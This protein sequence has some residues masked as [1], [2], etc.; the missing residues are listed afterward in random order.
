MTFRGK[1]SAGVLALVLVLSSQTAMAAAPDP[2]D[3]QVAAAKSVMVSN[4]VAALDGTRRLLD[5]ARAETEP[6]K[7]AIKTSTAQ[8]LQAEALFRANRS[9]EA[10]PVIS[11]AMAGISGL[12]KSKLQGDL[13]RTRGNAYIRLGKIQLALPDMHSAYDIYRAVGETRSQSMTLMDIGTIYQNAGD[14]NRVLTYYQQAQEIY[15]SDQILAFA[16]HNNKSN[17]YMNIGKYAEALNELRVAQGIAQSIKNRAWESAA[18]SNI[19]LV[20]IK[21]ENENAARKSINDGVMFAKNHHIYDD[22]VAF[23]AMSAELDFKNRNY[24]SAL[25]NIQYT[26]R[27]LN[28]ENTP[29]SFLEFHKYA[30][31]IYAATGNDHLALQHLKAYKRID[32]ETR[33]L[34]ADTNAALMAAKFDFANQD[35]KIANLKAGQLQ[36]D[37]KLARFR[38]MITMVLLAALAIIVGLLVVGLLSLKRSRDQVRAANINLNAVNTSLE[39]ALKAKTEFLATTSHEVRTPLNGILG[40]TQVILAD[41]RVEAGMR[42]KISIVHSAAE[43][44]R[45]LVDDILDVAKIEN[46][47]LTVSREEID[48]TRI[49]DETARMWR[50]KAA[51]KSLGFKLE[52]SEA[53]KRIV[54][55][56]ARLRQ[57]LFNLLSNAIKF[58]DVGE[59]GLT[60]KVVEKDGV[61]LLALSVSDTGIGIPADQFDDVFV[62]FKQLDG[63]TTRQHGGTGL[64]LTICRNLATAMDGD[65]TIESE[66]GKGSVFI[67]TLP[68]TRVED[69]VEVVTEDNGVQ[70]GPKT[71][72]DCTVLLVE[73]N[74]L[75]QSMMKAALGANVRALE[76][77]GSGALALSA[78][79]QKHFD[80][81]LAE[82][83]AAQMPD[84][85]R[86][87]SIRTLVAAAGHTPLSVLWSQPTEQD[88]TTLTALG[89]ALVLAKPI[90]PQGI[91]E[92]LKE[93]CEA[94]PDGGESQPELKPLLTA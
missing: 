12:P 25:N 71:L 62:S 84:K 1:I 91:V 19:A 38:T 65:I 86:M 74:P 82:G 41:Q 79:E 31:E 43:T 60:A 10:L 88:I 44:M 67:V 29:P 26:F 40:M 3:E 14:Y 73:A 22:M 90:S 2:F 47:N 64:G 58:T 75:A 66:V 7:R 35:L 85:E 94:L 8:W 16:I 50:E 28:I 63:G 15:S 70:D 17:A 33:A 37:I 77:V 39:K 57:V 51:T 36:R 21:L 93:S 54:E 45:A 18:I 42:D 87:E 56:G 89:V 27:D 78:L 23:Y 52:I 80:H 34:A 20:Y 81:V 46:G 61:E 72:A 5:I 13:L 4:P 55:D 49:L 59:V 83:A 11:E 76:I 53:P 69:P 92:R 24:K 32:D 30:Y 6:T 9:A 68:L 48:L